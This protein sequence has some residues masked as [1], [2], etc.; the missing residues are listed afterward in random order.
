MSWRATPAAALLACAIACLFASGPVQAAGP[1]RGDFGYA[2]RLDADGTAALY[3]LALPAEVY[4]H[5]A[6]AA[7]ADLRV[8]NGRGET[9]P[10]ALERRPAAADAA[11]APFEPVPMF[12]LR[13]D[14]AQLARGLNLSIRTDGGAVDLRS[15]PKAA[16]KQRLRG[17]LLDLRNHTRALTGIEAEWPDDTRDFSASVTVEASDDL[18]HWRTVTGA[19]LVNL[20]FEGQALRQQ[21]IETPPVLAKYWRVMWPADAEA[22]PLK[23]LRVS[24][25]PEQLPAARG[26]RVVPAGAVP[27]QGHEYVFD[28]ALHAPVDRVN[29]L[30]PERNSIVQAVL[31]SRARPADPWRLVG[32][33]TFYRLANGPADGQ[34][35]GAQAEVGNAPLVVGEDRDRYW[36][37][38]VQGNGLGDAPPQ[39]AVGWIPEALRFVARGEGPYELVFG[40]ALAGPAE[41][42][43]AAFA[44]ASAGQPAMK[45]RAA[46]AGALQELGGAAKLQPPALPLPWKQ[47]ILW[48]ILVIGVIALAL[49]AWR[50]TRD[51]DASR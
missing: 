21:R 4:A 1:V 13:G 8:L 15:L 34:A 29:L 49:L 35:S 10:Y 24:L 16:P 45:A 19:S 18:A 5:T 9:V 38:V 22:V 44:V 30:L 14:D 42:S 6:S 17:Y 11:A 46:T 32:S 43:L 31:H 39:L 27:G 37:V 41:T 2:M 20:T 33:G 47:W 3:E 40:N 51:M 25:A 36:R 23:A 50:L 12:P 28:L 7:M 26:Q 48:A